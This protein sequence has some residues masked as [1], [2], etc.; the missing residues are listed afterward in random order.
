[1][2]QKRQRIRVAGGL[3]HYAL[4]VCVHGE[5]SIREQPFK[6]GQVWLLPAEMEALVIESEN[7]GWLLTYPGGQSLPDISVE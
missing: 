7:A 2:C 5:G 3:P 1:L 6:K 4:F